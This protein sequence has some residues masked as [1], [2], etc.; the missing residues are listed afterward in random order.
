M[1]KN[2]EVLVDVHKGALRSKEKTQ[3]AIYVLVSHNLPYF[4]QMMYVSRQN[5]DI[6]YI[7][8]MTK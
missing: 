3:S 1:F 6:Y 7:L 5:Y 4:M 2:L 8:W